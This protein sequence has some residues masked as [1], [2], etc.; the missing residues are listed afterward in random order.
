MLHVS[1]EARLIALSY[2]KSCFLSRLRNPIFFDTSRDILYFRNEFDFLAFGEPIWYNHQTFHEEQKK[3]TCSLQHL[4]I[5]RSY[6]FLFL[7]ETLRLVRALQHLKSVGFERV[8]LDREENATWDLQAK[9]K[10][11]CRKIFEFGTYWN[12]RVGLLSKC[13]MEKMA[14]G[15]AWK[16]LKP[17]DGEREFI[18]MTGSMITR[19]KCGKIGVRM[20]TVEG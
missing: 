19:L 4:M 2:Y 14:N 13:E 7:D 5:A 17:E 20:D 18:T 6:P 15:R 9:L 12:V 16:D 10:D 8:P 1:K 3:P 11:Q